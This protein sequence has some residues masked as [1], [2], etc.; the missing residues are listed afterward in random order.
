MS[1]MEAKQVVIRKPRRCWGC[2]REFPA[3]SS[4]R[5]VKLANS[6]GWVT[7]YW[8]AVCCEVLAQPGYL[9]EDEYEMGD[10]IDNDPQWETIRSEVEGEAAG[11]GKENQ[12]QTGGALHAARKENSSHV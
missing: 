12:P 8:C 7:A 3:G 1:Y 4:L 11:G 2:C 10:L 5:R 6:D 9:Y